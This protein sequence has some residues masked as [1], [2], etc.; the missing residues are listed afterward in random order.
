LWHAYTAPVSGVDHPLV[1]LRALLAL[2]ARVNTG[3]DGNGYVDS[4]LAR[5]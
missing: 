4:V 5:D 2:G 3:P 1:V